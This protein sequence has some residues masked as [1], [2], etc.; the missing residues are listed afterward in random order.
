M[1]VNP[2]S[3]SNQRPKSL[4][5]VDDDPNVLLL[6]KLLLETAGYRVTTAE[7]GDRALQL[8]ADGTTA[9]LV[10]LDY[11]M[12]G[13]NGNELAA[14][15]RRD[16][17][18]LPLLAVSAVGQLPPTF[19]AIVDAH[20][21]KGRDPE[22]LLS[23]IS[24]LLAPAESSPHAAPASR[25]SI[26]CVEDEELQLTLRKLLF[27]DAGYVVYQARSAAAAMD[28]FRSQH[29]DAVVMDYWLS[30]QNGTVVAQQMKRLRPRTPVVMLSGWTSLPGEGAVVD[31]WLRK[32]EIEPADLVSEVA[33]LIE[34]RSSAQ[35]PMSSE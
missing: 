28:I 32:G 26:L 31:S 35:S 11:L 34:L 15:L 9:D 1:T 3:A 25:R 12:P 24:R 21:Q 20:L 19:T 30:G 2:Q 6:R 17:P 10:V 33:R 5:C 13:M 27:E 16:Y 8:L 22:I 18:S 4:L 14:I 29:I 23:A 7:S